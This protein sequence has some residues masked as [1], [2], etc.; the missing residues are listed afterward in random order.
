MPNSAVT[1]TTELDALLTTRHEGHGLPRAFY[2]D[3][4]LYDAEIRTIWQ[5]GWLFA[6]FEIE[7]PQPG[8]FLTLAVD[9]SSVLV[10]RDD[11]GSVRAFHNVCRHRGSQLCRN[12]SGHVRAIVCPY[13]SWTYSRQ[14]AL[15]ACWGTA[16][17]T[18]RRYRN[19]ATAPE[20]P[21]GL[22]R[23]AALRRRRVT[24]GRRSR[25]AA[26]SCRSRRVRESRRTRLRQSRA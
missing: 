8:D 19:C 18:G 1:P 23:S 17:T 16:N 3:A 7:I 25:A 9:G 5:G 12:E 15:V 2:H 4:A 20:R 13:H 10:I 11:A 21:E 22:R 14:G 6:G 26:S 24:R